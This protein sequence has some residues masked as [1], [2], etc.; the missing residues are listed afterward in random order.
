MAAQRNST[1]IQRERSNM[2]TAAGNFIRSAA[3]IVACLLPVVTKADL[4]FWMSCR[5]SG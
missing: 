3:L 4:G 1:T 5:A 2:K